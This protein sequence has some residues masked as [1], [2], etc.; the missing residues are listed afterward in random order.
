MRSRSHSVGKTLSPLE[1]FFSNPIQLF[2]E[3]FLGEIFL[4]EIF[5]GEKF[6][7]ENFL[8]KNVLG[9]NFGCK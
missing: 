7:G 2:F 8:G 6:L 5:F 4:G 9:E 1:D 3:N